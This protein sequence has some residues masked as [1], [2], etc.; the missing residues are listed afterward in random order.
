MQV[1]EDHFQENSLSNEEV[2]WV[3]EDEIILIH[4]IIAL[5]AIDEDIIITID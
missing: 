5:K 3:Q 2:G 4:E 1:E